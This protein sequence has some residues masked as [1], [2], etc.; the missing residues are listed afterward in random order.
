[1]IDDEALTSLEKLYRLKNEGVIT[2][3]DF[4]KAKERL[5]GAPAPRSQTVTTLTTNPFREKFDGTLPT[6]SDG[7]GWMLLPLRRYADFTGRSC[8]R[9]FWMFT[10]LFVIFCLGLGILVGIGDRSMF[11][12]ATVLLVL[13]AIGTLI[14]TLAVQVRRFHDQDKSGWFALLNFIP[15]VGTIIVLIFMAMDGTHGENRYGPD[16]LGRA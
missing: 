9:E 14:P 16:P 6:D 10:L 11:E 1:M 4:E 3:A 7:L 5:L 15:Y 2:E 8:R 13:G 12:L